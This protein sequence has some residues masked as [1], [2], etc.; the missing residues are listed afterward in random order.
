MLDS[1]SGPAGGGSA[2]G[3]GGDVW[4]SLS[5][6]AP[7]LR[8]TATVPHNEGQLKLAA[9]WLQNVLEANDLKAEK[10]PAWA[11]FELGL[12]RAKQRDRRA[13]NEAWRKAIATHDHEY[14]PRAACFMAVG[15]QQ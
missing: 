7:L 4:R 6:Q 11:A 9:D 12:V 10:V 3:A 5:A 14:A 1:I 15:Y 2:R 13:A 8:S